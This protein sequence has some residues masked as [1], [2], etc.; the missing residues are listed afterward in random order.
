MQ[1]QFKTHHPLNLLNLDSDKLRVLESIKRIPRNQPTPLPKPN[2]PIN[3]PLLLS[4]PDPKGHP[5]RLAEHG[6]R[7]P[8]LHVRI[9]SIDADAVLEV[10]EIVAKG[11]EARLVGAEGEP[12]GDEDEVLQHHW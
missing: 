2:P 7:R 10:A 5:E 4:P 1:V 9:I 8:D 3:N 6:H 11:P 12:D